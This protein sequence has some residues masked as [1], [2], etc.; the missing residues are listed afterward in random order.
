M[1]APLADYA[2]ALE[3]RRG[4]QLLRKTRIVTSPQSPH[5]QVDGKTLLAFCSNDYLGLASDPELIQAAEQAVRRYGVGA[6]ASHLISGHMQPHVALEAELAAFVSMPKALLF[7]TGYMAN[8]G[9]VTALLG[10]NDEAFADRLNHA[11]L[12]DACILSR[13]KLSRFAHN[14]MAALEKSLARS[15]AR[16]KLIVSDA[17][18]SMDGDLADVPQLLALAERYDALLLLDDAHGFGV[19]GHAGRGALAHFGVRSPRIIYMATLGK[20]LG[21]CGAFV[22]AESVLVETLQ[23]NARSYVYTTALPPSI[24]ETLRKSLELAA[25]GDARR[26]HLN[27]LIARLINTLELKR[28]RLIKSPTPIQPIVVGSNA[29][30]M[31]VAT[32]LEARGIWVPAI[33]PPTVPKNSARLRISLSAAHSVADVDRLVQAL[34]EIERR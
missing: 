10:R 11:S 13:A 27:A 20:A 4:A 7:S 9:V 1:I 28:W 19:L 21:V 32:E 15:R 25:A 29:E 33:R 22:A 14:D 6:G 17:V 8:L 12:N 16:R 23:Q 26:A 31:A 30:V 5:L 24:A 18:F 34:H 3:T 2:A